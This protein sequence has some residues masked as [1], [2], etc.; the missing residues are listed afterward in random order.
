M[1]NDWTVAS[2]PTPI[3]ARQVQPYTA[4]IHKNEYRGSRQSARVILPLVLREYQGLTSI[5]DVGGGVGAWLDAAFEIGFTNLIL[6]DS[7]YVDRSQI[8]IEQIKLIN[9]NLENQLPSIDMKFDLAVCVEVAEHLN[10]SR[11]ESFIKDLCQLSDLILF[12][13]AIPGQGGYK[14]VNEKWLSYWV[15]KF[16][17]NDYRPR[18]ILRKQIWE[19]NDVDW[20]YRQNIIL[21][22]RGENDTENPPLDLVHPEQFTSALKRT[23]LLALVKSKLKDMLR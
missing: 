9:H 15:A 14:H 11:A 6:I 17:E 13:A 20:W 8:R 18:D 5:V 19:N 10:E 16:E 2:I 12:S 4:E 3:Y 22:E 7:A 21:F 23:S 1:K